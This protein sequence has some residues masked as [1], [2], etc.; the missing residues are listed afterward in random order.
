LLGGIGFTM[1]LFLVEMA[2][3][4]QP[5]AA[6][7]AK[8]AVLASSTVAATAGAALMAK[9]PDSSIEAEKLKTA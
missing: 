8:L 5:S 7:V 1:C 9:L 3:A 6:N 4:G 2:L